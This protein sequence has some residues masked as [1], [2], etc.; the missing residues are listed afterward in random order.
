MYKSLI[1]NKPLLVLIVGC[2]KIGGGPLSE[3]V[4]VYDTEACILESNW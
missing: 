1:D 4:M 3:P 2:P